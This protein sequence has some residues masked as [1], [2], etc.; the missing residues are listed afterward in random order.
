MSHNL[1]DNAPEERDERAVAPADSRRDRRK[2]RERTRAEICQAAVELLESGLPFKDLT[3][4]NVTRA[5]GITRS[6]FYVHFHDKEDLLASAA[7]DVVAALYEQAE[8]F[9]IGEGP[10][11]ARIR[12]ALGGVVAIYARKGDILRAVVEA[13]TYDADISQLWARLIQRFVDSTAEHLRGEQQQGRAGGLDA[14]MAADHLVWMVERCGYMHVAT[15][16]WPA[17]ALTESLTEIWVS[18]LYPDRRAAH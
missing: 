12:D 16:D 14:E 6:A 18:L 17:D 10:P 15:G 8:R 9:W 7:E 1:Y 11:E 4:D 3:V 5:A 2:R 13:A